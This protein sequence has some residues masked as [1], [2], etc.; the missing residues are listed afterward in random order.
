[1]I[2][3]ALK[4]LRNYHNLKQKDLAV[5]LDLSPSHLSEI[6]AGS[7]PVSYDLLERYSQVFKMPVSNI[8][9]FAEISDQ[10]GK[11]SLQFKIADKALKVME[12]LETVS[13]IHDNPHSTR[14]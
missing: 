2:N 3:R 8:A 1:M 10:K 9:M 4:L 14:K 7:K 5:M 13:Q 6:E 11:P 12:W